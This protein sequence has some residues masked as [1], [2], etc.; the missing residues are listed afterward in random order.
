MEH[1]AVGEDDDHRLSLALGDEVVEDSIEF[2]DLVPSLLGVGGAAHEVE[3]GVFLV[4]V[5]VVLGGGVDDEG[6]V[7]LQFVR[8]VG[9][10]CNL[11]VRHVPDGVEHTAVGHFKE[12]RLEILV[13]EHV[14]IGGVG[15]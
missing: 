6:A 8:L 4:G 2:T 14:H 15:D 10:I 5:L 9:H 13:G 3:Y 11:A 12:R 1:I 7:Y